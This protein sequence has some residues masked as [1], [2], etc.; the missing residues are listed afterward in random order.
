M[1]PPIVEL[2]DLLRAL[3]PVQQDST[4][5]FVSVPFTSV[6]DDLTVIASLREP[7]GLSLV[8]PEAEALA[9]GWPILFRAAWITLTVASDLQAVGLT[10]AVSKALAEAGVASNVIAGAH[11]DHLFVPVERAAAAMQA[12]LAMQSEAR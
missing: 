7:E 6:I 2:R 8:L 11:H 10:A 1:P 9:R 3:H 12:L 5:A 4:F